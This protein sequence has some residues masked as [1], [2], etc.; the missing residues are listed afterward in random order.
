MLSADALSRCP[1]LAVVIG[2]VDF[3]LLTQIR[4]A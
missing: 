4:E 1:D 2:S 3:C